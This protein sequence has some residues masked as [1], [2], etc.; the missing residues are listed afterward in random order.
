MTE[1]VTSKGLRITEDGV[2]N[3]TDKQIATL[4]LRSGTPK[5]K[6]DLLLDLG[7]ISNVEP[8]EENFRIVDD[9]VKK[10]LEVLT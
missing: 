10:L 3:P 4:I 7:T 8:T 9:M 6:F 1:T 2:L 5:E